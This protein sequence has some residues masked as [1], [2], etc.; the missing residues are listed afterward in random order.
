LSYI[1]KTLAGVI[2]LSTGFVMLIINSLFY[3]TNHYDAFGFAWVLLF[4]TIFTALGFVLLFST[5]VT[6]R[7][8]EK[9]K[10]LR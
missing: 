2:F 1:G 7:Y 3:I 8:N 5:F 10:E 9:F 4:G 6:A